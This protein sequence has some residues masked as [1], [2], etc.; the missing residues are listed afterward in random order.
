LA[1]ADQTEYFWAAVLIY[2]VYKDGVDGW[3]IAVSVLMTAAWLSDDA[4]LF[5]R[6]QSAT[7]PDTGACIVSEIVEFAAD[8][9][10]SLA[11]GMANPGTVD[12]TYKRILDNG[13]VLEHT[14]TESTSNV[15]VL[16]SYEQACDKCAEK[17]ARAS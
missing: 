14:A 16:D 5:E 15:H 11:F 8:L 4:D 2:E 6:G 7:S 17:L 12:W 10:G 13:K 9:G 1:A 3:E